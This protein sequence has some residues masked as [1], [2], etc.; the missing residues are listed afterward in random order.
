MIEPIA[1]NDQTI[2]PGKLAVLQRVLPS[3]RV[4]FFDMLAE[5]CAGGLSLAAGEP[6][7][8]EAIDT[9]SGLKTAQFQPLMNIHLFKG[10]SYLCWQKGLLHW[11][12]SFNP[13]SLVVEANPRYLSTRKAISWMKTMDKPV[14]GW[15]LGSAPTEGPLKSIRISLRKKFLHHFDALIAYSQQGLE[16]YRSLGFPAEKIFIAHNAVAPKPTQPPIKRS[17]NRQNQPGILFVG[18]LQER[19]RIDLLIKACSNLPQEI[20]PKLVII[21]DGPEKRALQDLAEKIYPAALFTGALHGAELEPFFK[22]ADI[23]VLPGTGG[24]AIQ[25]AMCWSLPVIT[26]EGDG[27]QQDLVRKENG[28]QVA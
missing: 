11:L 14:I 1:I 5:K 28:W 25:Q 21:G 18:R 15:G 4:P 17:D 7:P 9:T 19:K 24:L 13:D 6:R 2:Y 16:Q 23:F 20:K 26:A 12:Q 22:A 8:D 3:Y 27:T 10:K